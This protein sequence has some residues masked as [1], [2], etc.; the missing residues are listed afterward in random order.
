MAWIDGSEQAERDL[1]LK[2]CCRKPGA[3]SLLSW[4]SAATGAAIM[5]HNQ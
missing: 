1:R 3:S 4:V 2:K 5:I